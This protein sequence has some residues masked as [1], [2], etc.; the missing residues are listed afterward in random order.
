MWSTTTPLAI[1]SLGAVSGLVS[2]W[3]L[4]VFAGQLVWLVVVVV[5]VVVL[6]PFLL[7]HVV[8]RHWT[9]VEWWWLSYRRSLSNQPSDSQLE[10]V[11]VHNIGL[12]YV[13]QAND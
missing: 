3:V 10:T 5:V 6:L 7:P 8:D 1:R 13:T 11:F 12:F 9:R 2:S 4:W